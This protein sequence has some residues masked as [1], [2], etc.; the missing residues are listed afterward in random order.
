MSDVSGTF[1]RKLGPL[2]VWGYAAIIVGVA[3]VFWYWRKHSATQLNPTTVSTVPPTGAADTPGFN[4]TQTPYS[5]VVS[6][7]PMGT[8]SPTTNAQWT[9]QTADQLTALGYSPDS[10]NNALSAYVNGQPLDAAG[11]SL[12]NVALQKFGNA[13]QGVLP[14]QPTDIHSFT[15]FVAYQGDPT[16]YGITATGQ[17]VGLTYAQDTA[18]GHPAFEQVAYSGTAP[19]RFYTWQQGDT[20]Q[21]VA[22]RYYGNS[23]PNTVGKLAGVNFGAQSFAPGYRIIVPQ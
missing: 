6:T 5:G 13:P 18:L 12:I 3:V 10:V 9:K 17:Q 14:V 19:Q 22:Q 8:P 4:Q 7:F 2:P 20:I 23:D 1:T 16:K 11:Q 21:S 15:K